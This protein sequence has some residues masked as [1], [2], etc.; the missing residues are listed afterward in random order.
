ML[1]ILSRFVG[2]SRAVSVYVFFRQWWLGFA[3]ALVMALL[4]V[5]LVFRSAAGPEHVAYVRLPVVGTEALN[6]DERNGIFVNLLLPDGQNLKLT[7]TEGL[8]AAS[9]SD[10]AGVEKLKTADTGAVSYRL[11]RPERCAD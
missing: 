7:E 11:R 10:T 4:V 5:F 6:G 8:I 1:S 3:F 2:P 9:I